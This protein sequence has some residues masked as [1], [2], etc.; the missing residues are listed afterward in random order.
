M[1]IWSWDPSKRPHISLGKV[2][3]ESRAPLTDWP[4]CSRDKHKDALQHYKGENMK[5]REKEAA[6]AGGPKLC[7]CVLGLA[8]LGLTWALHRALW[9]WH[10]ANKPR[11]TARG[12]CTSLHLFEAHCG[13]GRNGRAAQT[14][15]S[16]DQPRWSCQ[17]MDSSVCNTTWEKTETPPLIIIT[18]IFLITNNFNDKI[19]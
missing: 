13:P 5:Y 17:D 6:A 1:G 18:I 11:G 8:S 3:T 16:P 7:L 2:G 19:I 9:C 4:Q 14:P 10:T 15:P 12:L